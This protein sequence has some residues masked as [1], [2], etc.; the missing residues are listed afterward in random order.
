MVLLCQGGGRGVKGDPRLLETLE[1]VIAQ[2]PP[3]LARGPRVSFGG[4]NLLKE[5]EAQLKRPVIERLLLQRSSVQSLQAHL[6]GLGEAELE[7]KRG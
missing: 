6:N 3:C 4:L 1:E 7:E 5:Q 2:L